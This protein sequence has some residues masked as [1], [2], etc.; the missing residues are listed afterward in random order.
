MN[1]IEVLAAI[2]AS[3]LLLLLLLMA[4][5]YIQV[6]NHLTWERGT[7]QAGTSSHPTRV[8]FKTPFGKAPHMIPGAPV[9]SNVTPTGFEVGPA[10]GEAK[11]VAWIAVGPPA[12]AHS[13]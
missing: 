13:H 2:L 3:L 10:S 1:F 11:T 4:Y 7:A 5:A 12:A 9:T 6:R 8:T